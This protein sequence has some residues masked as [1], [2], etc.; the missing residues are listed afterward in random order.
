MQVSRPFDVDI[1]SPV[2]S[3]EPFS[4]PQV[5]YCKFRKIS[6]NNYFTENLQRTASNDMVDLC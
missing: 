3:A 6:K 4:E 5:F 2:F 1:V